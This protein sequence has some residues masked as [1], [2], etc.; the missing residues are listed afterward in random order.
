[1]VTDQ[2]K[3]LVV[4]D[5]ISTRQHCHRLLV[6][7]GFAVDVCSSGEDAVTLLQRQSFDL[8]LISL[9]SSATSCLD[10]QDAAASLAVPPALVVITERADLDAMT[11]TLHKGASAYLLRPFHAEQ[12]NVI[13]RSSLEQRRLSIENAHLQHQV[14][15]LKTGQSIS[16]LIDLECLI[17]QS[18]NV[19]MCEL[20][21]GSGCSFVLSDSAGICLSGVENLDPGYAEQLLSLLLSDFQLS[22]GLAQPRSAHSA[23]L[24]KML[25]NPDEMW[26]LPL[27]D[28]DVLKGGLLVCNA[29][30][31]PDIVI[32]MTDLLFLCDQIALGFANASRYQNAQQLMYT[33][34]L[35]GL[36]NH[37]YLRLALHQEMMRSKRY[38]L[39]FSLMFLDLDRFKEIND[40]YGHLAGSAA[41][42]EVG[43]LMRGCVRDVDTLSRFGGDEF[44]AMLVETDTHGARVVA[45][46][47]RNL[48]ESHVFLDLLGAPCQVTVTIGLATFPDDAETQERLLDLADQA[49]YA[50]KELRNSICSVSDIIR[51]R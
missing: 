35:T 10:V 13:V 33:D 17:Q 2:A 5:E 4:D 9:A 32:S 36:F 11:Q 14:E 31:K 46:R 8:V 50:G 44:A 25:Q 40:Q 28:G 24:Q 22:S 26:L 1:M 49:M 7:A 27:R 39:K 51:P 21:A 47:I 41:L 48:V 6:D 16:V 42:Q 12:L 45:E 30:R 15:L 19:L 43:Q 38:G 3:I 20:S 18:L 23:R 29:K 37:R 34:D